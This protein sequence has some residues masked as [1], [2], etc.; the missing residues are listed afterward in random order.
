MLREAQT[1]GRIPPESIQSV[2]AGEQTGDRSET[3]TDLVA[4]L[5]KC[6]PDSIWR[7]FLVSVTAIFSRAL[8]EQTLSPRDSRIY[9]EWNSGLREALLVVDTYNLSPVAALE[10]LS[11]EMRNAL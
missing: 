7:R 11:V 5:N 4:S 3:I 8:R 10:K 6:K 2:L 9:A 1:A